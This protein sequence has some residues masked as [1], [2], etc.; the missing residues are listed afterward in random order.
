M[1]ILDS[2]PHAQAYV[3]TCGLA[4]PSVCFAQVVPHIYAD[5][6]TKTHTEH[7]VSINC[8]QMGD[9]LLQWLCM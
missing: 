3:L 6:H 8:M 5:I 7:R 4:A 9:G 1:G 2:V